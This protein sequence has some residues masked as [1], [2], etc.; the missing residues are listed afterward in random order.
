MEM[1]SGENRIGLAD[2]SF[3]AACQ[4]VRVLDDDWRRSQI[5]AFVAALAGVGVVGRHSVILLRVGMQ[6]GQHDR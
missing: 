1:D 3:D 6:S 2:S 5:L 4:T